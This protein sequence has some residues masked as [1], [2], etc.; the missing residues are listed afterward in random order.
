MSRY[1]AAGGRIA[2]GGER[3]IGLLEAFGAGELL[4]LVQSGR[5]RL[6]GGD[7][8]EEWG[9]LELVIEGLGDPDPMDGTQ[10]LLKVHRDE[11]LAT[12]EKHYRPGEGPHQKYNVETDTCYGGSPMGGQWEEG[13]DDADEAIAWIGTKADSRP[14]DERHEDKTED[15]A[16]DDECPACGGD[17]PLT[18][19]GLLACPECGDT[20][21][22]RLSSALSAPEPKNASAG[23]ALALPDGAVRLPDNKQWTNRFEIKSESSD[24]VYTVA[25]N[26]AKGHWGCS[27]PSWR[28]RRTCKHLK[29]LGLPELEGPSP[30]TSLEPDAAPAAQPERPPT[31]QP[32]R[33]P[34]GALALPSGAVRLPDNEQ[35][36]NRFQI[37][38]ETSDRVYTVAQNRKKGHWGCS[39]PSWR[40]RRTCKHL[41]ALGLPELEKPSPIA[42]LAARIAGRVAATKFRPAPPGAMGPA[43]RD[44]YRMVERAR[45][46]P[47]LSDTDKAVLSSLVGVFDHTEGVELPDLEAL[48]LEAHDLEAALLRLADASAIVGDASALVHAE[49]WAEMRAAEEEARAALAKRRG[50]ER[51]KAAP[52]G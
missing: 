38:S 47:D 52:E 10:Y 48:D 3:D 5:L 11:D 1:H 26:K 37:R 20:D 15:K 9:E 13:F 27:C 29:A 31:A 42:V 41:K 35:W 44:I 12:E 4:P 40:T 14:D 39:C 28:T 18:P 51:P 22:G 43:V 2:G 16:P 34:P 24:R 8:D 6:I 30:I 46:L 25:Q 45:V 49:D 19:D 21:R 36:V 33:P 17:A 7:P 23:G 32:K 50:G